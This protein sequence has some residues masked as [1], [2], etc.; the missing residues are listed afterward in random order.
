M[1]GGFQKLGSSV[2]SF[3]SIGVLEASVAQRFSTVVTKDFGHGSIN[4]GS[5]L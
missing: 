5:F 3:I 2:F 4:H 1:E